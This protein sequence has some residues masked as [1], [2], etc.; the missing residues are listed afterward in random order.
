M[1]P[2]ANKNAIND[3]DNIINHKK[4][5]VNDENETK[6][7]LPNNKIVNNDKFDIIND[8]LDDTVRN[9]TKINE[10]DKNKQL[11]E[12]IFPYSKTI[13]FENGQITLE[14]IEKNKRVLLAE[15]KKSLPDEQIKKM[16]CFSMKD[17]DIDSKD[18]INEKIVNVGFDSKD[19]YKDKVNSWKD[20]NDYVPYYM[21][22]NQNGKDFDFDYQPNLEGHPGPS[23]SVILQVGSC[24]R[25]YIF[26]FI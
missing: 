16:N 3:A 15:L 7:T 10:I 13:E 9:D 19:K 1:L 4:T 24:I 26:K 2:D 25:I 18:Y 12:E 5:I 20:R 22:K 23:P 11:F 6:I 21:E 14:S 17:I 8:K